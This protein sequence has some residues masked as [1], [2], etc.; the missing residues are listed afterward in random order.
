[1]GNRARPVLQ[2]LSLD[3][4][5]GGAAGLKRR[6]ALRQR[7]GTASAWP[8]RGRQSEGK[9]LRMLVGA[10]NPLLS[11]IGAARRAGTEIRDV[12]LELSDGSKPKQSARLRILVGSRP[13]TAGNAGGTSRS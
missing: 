7:G 6:C 4:G 9:P 1:M 11:M 5:R 3:H 10:D 2:Y 13:R 8:A 12:A